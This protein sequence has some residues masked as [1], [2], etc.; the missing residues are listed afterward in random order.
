MIPENGL[1]ISGNNFWYS[2]GS[3]KMKAFRAY[4]MFDDVLSSLNAAS[5]KITWMFDGQPT[6]IDEIESEKIADDA[7]YTIQG[8][9]VGRG[10]NTKSLPSGIYI[11]NGQKVVIK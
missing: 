9:F 1:F 4:F 8:Q 6:S 2:V 5:A 10:I 7:V 3:T 11:M